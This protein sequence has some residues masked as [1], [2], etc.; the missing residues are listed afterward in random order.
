MPPKTCT[1]SLTTLLD[2]SAANS[3]A[4]EAKVVFF[5]PWSIIQADCTAST[6]EQGVERIRRGGVHA[7]TA[8][9]GGANR[10]SAMAV[11]GSVQRRASTRMSCYTRIAPSDRLS[12]CPPHLVRQQARRLDVGGHV[13]QHEGDGLVLRD[14]LAHR[15]A[16]QGVLQGLVHG[17]A[18]Q[19]DGAGGHWR[20][21]EVEGLQGEEAGEA[22]D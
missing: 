2:I 10:E 19:A 18:G 22:A 7:R 17:A 5:L 20:A 14:G 6:G 12:V 16:L 15:L 11:H 13:G 3:L 8:M 9:T 4:M 1:A 21:R